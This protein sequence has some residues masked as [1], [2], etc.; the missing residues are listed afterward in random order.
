[1]AVLVVLAGTI[2]AGAETADGIPSAAQNN[3]DNP[4]AQVRDHLSW[5][6]GPFVNGGTGLGNRDNFS[7]FS[8]GF[9]AGRC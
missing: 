7:F 6:Y 9:Q 8:V 5:E 2:A 3:G 1:M 4:V